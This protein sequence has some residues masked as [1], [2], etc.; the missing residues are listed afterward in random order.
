MAGGRSG[1]AENY[2]QLQLPLPPLNYA[3]QLHMHTAI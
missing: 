3:Q 1:V 2:A